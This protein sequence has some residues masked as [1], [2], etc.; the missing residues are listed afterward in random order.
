MR[1]GIPLVVSGSCQL[2]RLWNPPARRG[3]PHPDRTWGRL[4]RTPAHPVPRCLPL[5]RSSSRLGMVQM[6][7]IVPQAPERSGPVILSEAKDLAAGRERPFTSLRVTRYD[8]SNGQEPFVQ[9]EPCLRVTTSKQ[10]PTRSPVDPPNNTSQA[11]CSRAPAPRGD[12][13]TRGF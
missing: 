8:C 1:P 3:T 7:L 2:G 9:I 10:W 5:D 13:E 12:T 11:G 4:E 6:N